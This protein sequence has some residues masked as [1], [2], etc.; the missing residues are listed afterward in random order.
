MGAAPVVDGSNHQEGE[1]MKQRAR[2]KRVSERAYR[3][4]QI[5]VAIRLEMGISVREAFREANRGHSD[6]Q[7][8]LESTADHPGQAERQGRT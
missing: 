7:R 2:M 1:G 6:E 8:T 4:T 3:H 5:N